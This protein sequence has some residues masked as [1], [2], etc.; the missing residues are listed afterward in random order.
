MQASR[1]ATALVGAALQVLLLLLLTVPANGQETTRVS[2]DS[3]GVEGNGWSEGRSMSADGQIVAFDSAASNLVAGDTNGV[4]DVFVHDR[5]ETATSTNYGTGFA[6]TNG[7]PSFTSQAD[8]VLGS[9]VTLDL[10]NSYGNS[11]AGLVLVGYQETLVSTNKGGDLL[12]VPAFT[13]LVTLAPGGISIAGALPADDALCGFEVFVQ[14]LELDPGAA[15][16]MSFT[17][18]L[19]LVLGH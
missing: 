6:G 10:A 3:S 18:G 14:A 11:T 17:A 15:K 16:G 19:K 13:F 8:P 4:Q 1:S 9:T 12:L 2:V 7:V 5:C